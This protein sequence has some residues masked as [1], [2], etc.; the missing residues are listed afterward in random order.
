MELA[1]GNSDIRKAGH[2]AIAIDLPGME[3][4]NPYS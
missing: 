1:P 4:I 3:E 2:K